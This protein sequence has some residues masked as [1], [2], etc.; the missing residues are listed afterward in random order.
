MDETTQKKVGISA[1]IPPDLYEKLKVKADKERRSMA[2][3]IEMVL[4]N[5]LLD[6]NK[7]K[8]AAK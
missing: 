3:V 8:G 5:A 1:T 6:E 7:K 2:Q 4:E